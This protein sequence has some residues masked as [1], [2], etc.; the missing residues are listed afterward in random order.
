M[1]L[2]V[3]GKYLVTEHAVELRRIIPALPIVAAASG[4]LRSQGVSETARDERGNIRCRRD[5]ACS[6]A[7][8]EVTPRS[9]RTAQVRHARTWQGQS[10]PIQLDRPNYSRNGYAK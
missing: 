5:G 9:S 1:K 10:A 4:F 2:A 3:R 6:P 7:H 8:L